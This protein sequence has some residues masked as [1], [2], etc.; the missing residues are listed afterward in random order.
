MNKRLLLSFLFGMPFVA[1]PVATNADDD[2]PL[3]GEEIMRLVRY[4][5]ALQ[6]YEFTG[7]LTNKATDTREGFRLRMVDGTVRFVFGNPPQAVHLDLKHDRAELREAVPGRIA[8]IPTERLG[9]RLRGT[10]MNFEDLSMRFLYWPKPL[11]ESDKERVLSQKCWRLRVYAPDAGAPGGPKG[12]Y[13]AV[14]VWVDQGSG[15]ILKM[16]AYDKKG[17]IV[18]RFEVKKGQKVDGAWILKQMSIES[19]RSGET[20]RSGLTYLE[21]HDP[22]RRESR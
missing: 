8:P 15:G 22:I 6:D 17:K 11:I 14:R 9:E 1:L 20:R 5:N 19:F 7:V 2:P 16:E 21:L 13:I 10:D 4:S 12:P 3:T 18:K